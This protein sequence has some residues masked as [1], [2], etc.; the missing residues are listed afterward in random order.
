MLIFTTLLTSGLFVIS[1]YID[2]T[3]NIIDTVQKK[4]MTYTSVLISLN[5]TEADDI[6]V[7]GMIDSK[8]DP[9]GYTIPK[10]IIK[11]KKIDAK[12]KKYS[13]YI[14]MVNDL[15]DKKIDAMFVSSDFEKMFNSYENLM[16][17]R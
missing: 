6:E 10:E 14:S 13:D 16:V 11:E 12:T 3:Y 1:H 9:T 8:N 7:I 15:Y 5:D 17:I 4:Y 2:K